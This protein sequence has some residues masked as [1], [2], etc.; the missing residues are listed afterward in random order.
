MIT[1]WSGR[2][3]V[4]FY[5]E[6]M[7]PDKTKKKTMGMV[8][9]PLSLVDTILDHFPSSIWS[10]PDNIFLDPSAG[11]GGFL[12][13]IYERLMKGLSEK[14]P[15]T[16]RRREHIIQ[17]MLVAAELCPENVRMLRRV[18]GPR[19]R[20]LE[21]DSLRMD[22]V[23]DKKRKYTAVVGNPPFEDAGKSLWPVF[24]TRSLTEWI[25]PGG[26]LGMVLPPGWRKPSDEKSRTAGIW[27]LMTR[28]NRCVWIEMFGTARAREVFGG[29]S[30]QFDAVVIQAIPSA[31]NDRTV[32]EPGIDRV[33]LRGMPF[34]PSGHAREW[35]RYFE[36]GRVNIGEIVMYN[37]SLYS[38]RDWVKVRPHRTR[39]Y[40]YPVVKAVRKGGELVLAYAPTRHREGGFGV[41]KVIFNYFGAWNTPVLDADGKYGMTEGAFA[42]P[43]T[44]VE[45][46]RAILRFFHE[47]MLRIFQEDMTWGTSTQTCFWKLFR[48][49]PRR[50][51]AQ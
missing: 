46:G 36:R 34:L 43:I 44:S 40:R 17:N 50:F 18:F 11:M 7:L 2:D 21:G 48:Y 32:V 26:Y 19:M 27:N 25:A 1:T 8:F 16:R 30:I 38:V 12:L 4:R 13:R 22:L 33:A 47:D 49:L 31:K 28:K 37:G 20:V 35:S 41:P 3:L 5:E 23:L 9:T 45:D 42:L 10:D 29:V 24:V 39:E 15:S 6:H 51:Y 14:I